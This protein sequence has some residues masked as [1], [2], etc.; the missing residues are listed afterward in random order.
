[1]TAGT[2]KGGTSPLHDALNGA[3]AIAAGTRFA[4]PPID[5]ETVLEISQFARGR[6]MIPQRR[7]AGPDRLFKDLPHSDR[8]PVGPATLADVLPA[9]APRRRPSIPAPR[10][11]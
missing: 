4:C 10:D 8:K 2:V 7:A 3:T 11:P 9:P 1:M 5:T 6:D